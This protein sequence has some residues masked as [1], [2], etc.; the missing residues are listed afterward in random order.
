MVKYAATSDI[1]QLP[2][3]NKNPVMD[4]EGMNSQKM[5]KQDLFSRG[6]L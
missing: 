1:C 4:E 3:S 6:H 5:K 2:A